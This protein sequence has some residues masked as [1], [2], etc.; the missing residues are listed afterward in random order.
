MLPAALLIGCVLVALFVLLGRAPRRRQP[1]APAPARQ[2]PDSSTEVV[3]PGARAP[4]LP[5]GST[6]RVYN[7]DLT[8]PPSGPR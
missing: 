3:G 2:Q 5:D 1:A 6:V 8:R 4:R 7:A